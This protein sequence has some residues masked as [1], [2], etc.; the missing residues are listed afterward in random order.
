FDGI[1]I[2]DFTDEN[3]VGVL[4]HRCAQPGLERVSVGS[5]FALRNDRRLVWKYEFNGFFDSDDMGF[6]CAI[7]VVDDGSHGGGFTVP[8]CSRSQHQTAPE[9]G[10]LLHDSRQVEFFK[11]L[12][13]ERHYSQN[14]G[15]EAPLPE[16]IDPISADTWHIVGNVELIAILE[17]L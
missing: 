13:M 9:I 17:L 8:G 12:Y 15:V 3:D 16:Y 1:A 11:G 7:Y 5:D 6:S 4:A 2:P 14:G 10:N